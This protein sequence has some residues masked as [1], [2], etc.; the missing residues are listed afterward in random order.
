M[1]S[2]EELQVIQTLNQMIESNEE[3]DNATKKLME[4][5]NK[6]P[7]FQEIGNNILQTEL[8]RLAK[9]TEEFKTIRSDLLQKSKE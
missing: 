7:E 2:Y 6:F 4:D 3:F 5:M 9:L 8:D 1:P